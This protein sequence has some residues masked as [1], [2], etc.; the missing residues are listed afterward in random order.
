MTFVAMRLKLHLFQPETK[1]TLIE[2]P[3]PNYRHRTF[4]FFFFVVLRRFGF[5]E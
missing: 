3:G 1:T 4:L 2:I 5:V